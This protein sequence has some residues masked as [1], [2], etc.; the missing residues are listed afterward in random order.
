MSTYGYASKELV[1]NFY[2][3]LDIFYV[4]IGIWLKIEAINVQCW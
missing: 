4:I 3:L 1:V 2:D